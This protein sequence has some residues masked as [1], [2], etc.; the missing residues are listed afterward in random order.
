MVHID[1]Y[2]TEEDKY[3]DGSEHLLVVA[4]AE[5][6]VDQSFLQRFRPLVDN[7]VDVASFPILSF[8]AACLAV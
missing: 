1:E 5:L 4:P 6:C 2:V 7:L 8:V 3:Q